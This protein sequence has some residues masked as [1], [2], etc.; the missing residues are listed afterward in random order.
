MALEGVPAGIRFVSRENHGKI[1]QMIG[2]GQIWGR[3][4]RSLFHTRG[5]TRRGWRAW[6]FAAALCIVCAFSFSAAL[7]AG[8]PGASA[9]GE[10]IFILWNGLKIRADG[11]AVLVRPGTAHA[12]LFTGRGGGLDAY[13]LGCE[14]AGDCRVEGPTV[15][16]QAPSVPGNYWLTVK[17]ALESNGG[18]AGSDVPDRDRPVP[19]HGNLTHKQTLKL[20]CLVGYP[21]SLIENGYLNGFEL[22]LY[23]D[24]SGM[25]TPELYRAPD[26]FFHL[27]YDVLGLWISEHIKLE[28]LAY[29]RRA[30]LPQYSA[31]DYELVK[32]LEVLLAELKSR[33]LPARY[34]Y[35]GSGFISPKS[36]RARVRRNRAAATLSRHMYGGAIDFV[37]DQD[38]GDGVMDDMNRDGIIDVRDA[39]FVR[40]IITELEQEGRVKTG[41]VGVYSPPQN[42]RIQMHMDVRGFPSRWGVEEYDPNVFVGAPVKKGLR[43]GGM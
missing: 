34:H 28:D 37:I 36:N 31:L 25:R 8:E 9:D 7:W 22:G 11:A 41:G 33:G 3:G 39:L 2:K 6:T 42:S 17:V 20:A 1:E 32:K 21:S 19:D 5:D 13:A 26:Y 23:P 27:E 35:I 18:P 29:D 12:F 40:D 43:P 30:P 24:T 38:S 15:Y 16:W 4:C 10:G 14:G